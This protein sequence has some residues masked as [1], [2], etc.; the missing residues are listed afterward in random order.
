MLYEEND[1]ELEL[2]KS[3]EE[4]F[5]RLSFR[6]N[7]ISNLWSHQA[8]LL[9]DFYS[10]HQDAPDICLELPTGTG[11]TLVGLLIAEWRR[12]KNKTPVIYACPTRQ[13]ASQVCIAAKRYGFPVVLLK[14]KATSWN[15]KDR[16]Q[17]VSASSVAITTYSS[18]FNISPK[19]TEPGTIILDDAHAGE[20][21]VAQAWSLQIGRENCN[22]DTYDEVVRILEPVLDKSFLSKITEE[23]S[24]ED[25]SPWENLRHVL[26][27]CHSEIIGPLNNIFSRLEGNEMFRYKMI[28]DGLHSC[29]L[30]INSREIL[31]RPFIPPTFRNPIFSNAKQRVYLSATL[32]TAGELERSFARRDIQKLGIKSEVPRAGRRL[33]IFPTYIKGMSR[34]DSHGKYEEFV[35]DIIQVAK[36]AL[37]LS[38]SERE[39]KEI[40]KWIVPEGW[41]LLCKG[42]VE[43]SLEVFTENEKRVLVLANRYDGMDFPGNDCRLIIIYGHSESVHLQ[44][45]FLARIVHANSVLKE[46]IRTRMVQGVGRCTRGQKDH[47]VVLILDYGE[48]AWWVEKETQ[49]SFGKDLYSEVAFGHNI[50]EMND[51]TTIIEGV[52][53]F[54][55]QGDDWHKKYE[56]KILRLRDKY[57][58]DTNSDSNKLK[59]SVEYEIQACMEA[60]NENWER[61][62]S[63]A[64][65]VVSTLAD[66][67][68]NSNY[69]AFWQYLSAALTLAHGRSVRSTDIEEQAY[70]L[71]DKAKRKSQPCSWL[72]GKDRFFTEEHLCTDPLEKCA[73]ENVAK[74]LASLKVEEHQRELSM[75]KKDLANLEESKYFEKGITVLGNYLGAEAY[76]PAGYGCCD[77]A[78]CYSDHMWIAFEA[79]SECKQGKDVSFKTARQAMTHL[80][81]LQTQRES[82]GIPPKSILVIVQDYGDISDVAKSGSNDNVYAIRPAEI[83]DF[84]GKVATFLENI[85]RFIV[86][87][88][89]RECQSEQ[90][91]KMLY[92]ELREK[93][94][95]PNDV[96]EF[97]T[98]TP[99]KG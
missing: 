15:P 14:G 60:W 10:N 79:K 48:V 57:G 20:N 68:E 89:Y 11:K 21:F 33:F 17:Y 71:Y 6:D 16:S 27:M 73:V 8:D 67:N 95:L 58:N 88:T 62:S 52:K 29:V 61:A 37:L 41:E 85:F 34:E 45:G 70:N 98:R 47:A 49:R 32:G 54:F 59:E 24:S 78:W 50:S 96:R 94:L 86:D 84:A 40:I 46:R 69:C 5:S 82:R 30:Y 36:K 93:E 56:H 51:G 77:S 7:S 90:F 76:K 81:T 92:G 35:L 74:R 13:L 39:S 2:P 19:L 18:I 12:Q 97:L 4:L 80:N 87:D 43:N 44:E 31:V 25:M 53:I 23:F 9:R 99:V 22:G 55:E 63:H 83:Q 26:L 66:E 72:H 28:Q 1:L 75:M 42:D 3:P 64:L 65:E 91:Q 38:P